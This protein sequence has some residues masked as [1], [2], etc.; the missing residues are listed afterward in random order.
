MVRER[1]CPESEERDPAVLAAGSSRLGENSRNPFAGSR[2]REGEDDPLAG[3]HAIDRRADP[4]AIRSREPTEHRHAI[5]H[6]QFERKRARE[7]VYQAKRDP[8]PEPKPEELDAQQWQIAE[9]ERRD[10]PVEQLPGWVGREMGM[11][12]PGRVGKEVIG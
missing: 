3:S 6:C 4:S 8:E 5:R 11:D 2:R 10:R 12:E 7:L 1:L 9:L